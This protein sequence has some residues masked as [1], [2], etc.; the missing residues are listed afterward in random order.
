LEDCFR[1]GL[2][3]ED[4]A[5]A[6]EHARQ[7]ASLAEAGCDLLL[8]ETMATAR[9]ARAAVTAAV[10]TGKPTW[11]SFV[12][13][14]DGRLLSGEPLEDAARAAREAG[15]EAVLV[16]CVPVRGVAAEVA[17]LRAAVG[18]P[19]GAY[20]NVGHDREVGFRADLMLGPDEFAAATLLAVAG[21]AAI[22]GGCC[23]T[24]PRHLA[25]LAAALD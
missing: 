18:G 17:R 21:G 14:G 12:T 25:A 16:N 4:A 9:E 24:E 6:T 3:P 2:V 10:A 19:V 22:V 11:C 13:E 8:V 15:A 7:A 5:L 1:P 23:G 20:G